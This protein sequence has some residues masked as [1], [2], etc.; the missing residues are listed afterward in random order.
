M[1]EIKYD[2]L[3]TIGVLSENSRGWKKELNFISWNGGKPKY[4]IR[5]WAPEHEKMGKGVTLTEE[6][7][8]ALARI[9]QKE[10]IP[11]AEQKVD[12]TQKTAPA[13]KTAVERKSASA[14]D[15]DVK[16]DTIVSPVSM[17]ALSIHPFYAM[18]I[19]TGYKT[20]ECRSWTTNYRGDI[21]ICST[22]KKEKGTIPGHALGVVTLQDIVPFERKHLKGAMMDEC[23]PGDYAWI[24]TNPRV[25]KPFPIKG[26][27]SL[28]TCEHE[29]EFL[30]V[31]K[32][33]EEDEELGRLY[34]DPI[35][36]NG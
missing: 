13:Q 34:W 1:A 9:L 15:S 4:D 12:A 30:P 25:I 33:E 21:L 17:K 14:P 3:R 20:V 8:H 32:N 36:Y 22:A 29:I 27:L 19:V 18:N 2:I 31:P 23:Y 28:W 16:K 10:P 11:V 7:L 35:I 6:E 24:L 5:D 26:K